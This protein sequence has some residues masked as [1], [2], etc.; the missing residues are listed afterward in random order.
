MVCLSYSTSNNKYE[1]FHR[2]GYKSKT[3][4]KA[5]NTKQVF[6]YSESSNSGFY[7]YCGNSYNLKVE[8]P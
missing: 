3:V 5:L 6:L 7:G 1:I 2:A 8:K 4:R